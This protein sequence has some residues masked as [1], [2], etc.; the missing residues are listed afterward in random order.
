[1]TD[2]IDTAVDHV[3]PVCFETPLDDPPTQPSFNQL[4]PCD[5]AVLAFGQFRDQS[6]DPMIS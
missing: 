2:R 3:E 5:D 6:I 4:P 1:V